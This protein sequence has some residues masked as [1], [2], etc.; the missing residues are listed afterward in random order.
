M[1]FK[2]DISFRKQAL[3]DLLENIITYENDILDALYK[4]FKKPNFEGV[5]TETNYVISDLKETISNIESW[6][7]PKKVTASILNF[8]SSDYIYSEPYGNVL[9]ISPWNYPFQLALCP[10]IAAVTAGN[11]VTLKPSEL[12]PNTSFIIA[13]II[14]ETFNEKHVVAIL[15]DVGMAQQLLKQK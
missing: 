7:R 10:L 2:N 13:K 8:P 4:D 9:I 15:G 12:T 14:R 11:H 5:L 3:K 1:N 6:A